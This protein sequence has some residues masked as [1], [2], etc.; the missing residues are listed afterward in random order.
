MEKS[1]SPRK[2]TNYITKIDRLIA[3]EFK[4]YVLFQAKNMLEQLEHAVKVNNGRTTLTK[5]DIQ[6]IKDLIKYAEN[7]RK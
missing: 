7:K 6:I 4:L 1:K 5:T 2:K 3:K